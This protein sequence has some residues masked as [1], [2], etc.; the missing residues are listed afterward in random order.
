[1]DKNKSGY[2]DIVTFCHDQMDAFFTIKKSIGND[3]GLINF[4][5]KTLWDSFVLHSGAG[6]IAFGQC[7]F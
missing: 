6:C 4:I 7:T 1:M 5:V 3:W 2:K